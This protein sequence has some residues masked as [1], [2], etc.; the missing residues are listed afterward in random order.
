MNG[1]G[2]LDTWYMF[3]V[4]LRSFTYDFSFLFHPEGGEAL[5][6]AAPSLRC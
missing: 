3:F 5:A 6:Q 1:T 2:E 4:H